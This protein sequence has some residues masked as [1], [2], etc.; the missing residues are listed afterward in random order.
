MVSRRQNHPWRDFIS[1]SGNQIS[2]SIPPTSNFPDRE[3]SSNF[4]YLLSISSSNFKFGA[5]R[6]RGKEIFLSCFWAKPKTSEERSRL[7][8]IRAAKS[9]VDF[10]DDGG[11]AP[12]PFRF[13]HVLV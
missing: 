5:W 12:P 7:N 2:I 10:L 3:N 8:R 11:T 1:V 9:H 6:V 13:S 4:K